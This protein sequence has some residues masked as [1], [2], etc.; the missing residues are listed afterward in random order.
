MP[1]SSSP[2]AQAR[3]TPH[4]KEYLGIPQHSRPTSLLPFCCLLPGLPLCGDK[5]NQRNMR[6]RELGRLFPQGVYC[7]QKTCN[8]ATYGVSAMWTADCYSGPA[9]APD[10]LPSPPSSQQAPEQFNSK[11]KRDIRSQGPLTTHQSVLQSLLACVDA[12]LSPLS[13]RD[14]AN[15]APVTLLG[16]C[17]LW[18]RFFYQCFLDHIARGSFCR[19]RMPKAHGNACRP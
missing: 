4:Y 8:P 15:K 7:A 1:G 19:A 9:A 18:Q 5:L 12:W 14:A 10:W 6:G 3:N 16:I 13:A 11:F 2:A 17:C